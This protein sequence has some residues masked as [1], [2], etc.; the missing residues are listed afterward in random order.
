MKTFRIQANGVPE[1]WMQY[2]C[3]LLL[4]PASI[5]EEIM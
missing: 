2:P 3:E 4:F 5:E 1:K